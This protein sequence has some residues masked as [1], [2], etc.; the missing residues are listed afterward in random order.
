MFK[1]I[2]NN[3]AGLSVLAITVALAAGMF[4]L[5]G[6]SLTDFVPVEVPREVQKATGTGSKVTLTE[7]GPVLDEYV[8]AGEQFAGNIDEAW[9]RFGYFKGLIET[10]VTVG[11]AYI[12]GGAGILAVLSGVG[13]L[14]MKGPGTAKA[15]QKSYNKGM[16]VGENRAKALID[17]L[18]AAG[19]LDKDGNPTSS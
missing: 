12:P 2:S 17:S 5:S 8:K 3:K 18:K 1:W 10:G 14:L 15:E 4:V 9:E 11:S 19:V 6:C 13:G 16:E 7:A